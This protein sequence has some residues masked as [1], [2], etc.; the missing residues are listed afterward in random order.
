MTRSTLRAL[1]D[2]IER[3]QE[4]LLAEWRLQVRELPS[5]RRLDTPTLNDH[6]PEFLVEL[7]HALRTGSEE[8]IAEA[9]AA[10]TPLEHGEQRTEDNFDI[11]EVVAEYNIL[12]GCLHDLADR[13]GLTL[14][15]EPFHVLNRVF[16]SAIGSAVKS[17]ATHQARQVLHRRQE[18]LAFVAH[19]LR[20]PLSAIALS[21][22]VLE[23]LLADAVS[24][25]PQASLMFATMQRSVKLLEALVA[26]VLKEN[27]NLVTEVGARLERRHVYLWPLVEALIYD[28]RPI[29][30]SG[31]TQMINEVPDDLRVH[32]DAELLKR[33]LQNLIANA[34]S[35]TPNGEIRIGACALDGS[36]SVECFVQDNGAG[37]ERERLPLVFT[38]HERDA[39]KAGSLGL[40]LAIVKTFV[41]AH[42]GTVSVESEV[43]Q[44]S[45]F[46][47]TL[48]GAESPA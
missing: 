43:G 6:I 26:K 23:T 37:I 11:E 45:T 30:G 47:F 32:A 44:G 7:V 10:D 4:P 18:Y 31:S 46:R 29:A 3:E 28:L 5:A 33:I 9:V 1:A 20:T 38:K 15:G 13:Q 39:D 14:Q 48:P 17:F 25:Q 41:E 12:R 40:G 35:Y 21:A 34:I 27:A 8:T 22:H 42:G 16:D 2:L 36:G 24:Q 19:D